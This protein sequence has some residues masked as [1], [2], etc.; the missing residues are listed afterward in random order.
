MYA[1]CTNNDFKVY[2]YMKCSICLIVSRLKSV[3]GVLWWLVAEIM[4]L[5]P[6]FGCFIHTS[7]VYGTG[8]IEDGVS[9]GIC[10]CINVHKGIGSV[11]F[12]LCEDL[13]Q[14]YQCWYQAYQHVN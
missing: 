2:D 14:L 7:R 5:D 8:I 4:G 11:S 10:V 3:V 1:C 9:H 13:Y 6:L 12:H